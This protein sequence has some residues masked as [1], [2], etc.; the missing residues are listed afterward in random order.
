MWGVLSQKNACRPWSGDSGWISVMTARGLVVTPTWDTVAMSAVAKVTLARLSREVVTEA[1]AYRF[2]EHLRWRGTPRCA[3]C[4]SLDVSFIAP[5][6]GISRK[7]ATG[8]MSE[9]RVWRCRGCTKQFS[10]LTGTVLHATKLP[11]RTWVL[12]MFEMCATKNGT[13]A[14]EIERKYGLTTKTA[15]HLL[16]RIRQAMA[17]GSP[18]GSMRGTIVSDETWMGGK[19]KWRHAGQRFGRGP[20]SK[21]PVLTL[22]NL[23]TGEVRSQTVRKV[24]AA[25]LRQ[26]IAAQVDMAN[27]EL[28][29][30]QAKYY[31]G[32]GRAF[33]RHGAVNH[34]AG[35]YARGPVS[36]NLAEG[37][38]AQLKRSLD[39]THQHVSPVHLPRYLGEFD[40]RYHTCKMSDY[41]RMRTLGKQLEGRLSYA[42]LTTT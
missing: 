6:N 13:S 41:G 24:N 26:A 18:L 20:I 10:V 19:D 39:G 31:V 7:S 23:V 30:D 3:H 14:R 21:T 33:A 1:D 2:M 25:T 17:A 34:T 40:F 37:F 5:S 28:F 12:V 29:S 4:D 16:H 15:W 36:T 35:E 9:R 38:F 42:E 32:I 8:T 11:I 27:S 22:V